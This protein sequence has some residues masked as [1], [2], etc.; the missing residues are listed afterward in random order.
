MG[1]IPDNLNISVGQIRMT[2]FLVNLGLVVE[3]EKT[4]GE[5][6]VDCYLPELKYVV[7]F[8]GGSYLTH[9]GKAKDT[10]DKVLLTLGVMKVIHVKGTS[11]EEL[12]KLK[13]ELG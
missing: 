3:S 13:E 1:R 5:Y 9:Y 6:R 2:A 4:I 11:K 10:R 12:A 7:E 8:D